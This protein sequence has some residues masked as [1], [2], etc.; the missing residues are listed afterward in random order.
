MDWIRC[1]CGGGEFT[2][3][4][5]KGRTWL[6]CTDGDCNQPPRMIG[7]D[8]LLAHLPR[9]TMSDVDRMEFMK[10]EDRRGGG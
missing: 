5:A 6:W 4:R 2:V 7:S 8:G 1:P 10:A 9:E 3:V